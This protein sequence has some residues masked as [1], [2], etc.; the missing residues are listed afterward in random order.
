VDSPE[1]RRAVFLDRDGVL[2]AAPVRNGSPYSARVPGEVEVLP[3]VAAACDALREAGFVIVVVTNQPDVA[4]GSQ[5]IVG[6][7]AVNERLREQVVVDEIVVCP[8]DDPDNCDCRKPRPGMLVDAAQRRNLDLGRSF[9]VGDRWRD[10]GAGRSAGCTVVFVDHGY[11]ERLPG[12]ADAVVPDLPGAA[13]W[14][15]LSAGKVC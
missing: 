8:H 7:E 10:V 2:I 4:R 15:L 1:P 5:T 13:E 6:V 3:G 14:I 11:D 12:P 9:M